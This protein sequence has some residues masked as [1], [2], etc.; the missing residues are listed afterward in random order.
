MWS[1]TV[2]LNDKKWFTKFRFSQNGPERCGLQ[3][4]VPS[5][6]TIKKPY[7]FSR[8]ETK[9]R[10]IVEA[11]GISRR[12]LVSTFNHHLALRKL[13]VRWVPSL[14]TICHCSTVICKPGIKQQPKQMVSRGELA[15][16]MP[17]TVRTTIFRNARGI[18]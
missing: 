14:L 10:Q 6:E 4:E 5:L 18:M 9:V 11:I 2:N 13:S 1:I 12:L 8:S 17:N 7:G 3:I 16:K 15:P